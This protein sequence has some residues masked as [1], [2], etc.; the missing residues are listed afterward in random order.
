MLLNYGTATIKGSDLAAWFTGGTP[1]LYEFTVGSSKYL[2]TNVTSNTASTISI[3]SVYSSG[4]AG[5][6]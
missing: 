1:V 2:V 5:G 6:I 3:P 4:V